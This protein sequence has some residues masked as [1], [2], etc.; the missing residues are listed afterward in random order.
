[1]PAVGVL[2]ADAGGPAL[3]GAVFVVFALLLFFVGAVVG[4]VVYL[5]ARGRAKR[6]A[7]SSPPYPPS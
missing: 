4:L 7:L 1:M 2:L 5:I 6:R 3:A